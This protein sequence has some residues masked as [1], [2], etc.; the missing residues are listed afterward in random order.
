MSNPD[1]THSFDT[2]L[3]Y[4]AA[5]PQRHSLQGKS[6]SS[7]LFISETEDQRP[8]YNSRKIFVGGL[9][10]DLTEE[11]TTF[12]DYFAKYGEIE[13][14]V[15][16]H[17]RETGKP[18]GFGFVT[19]KDDKSVDLVLQDKFKHKIKNKWVECKRATPKILGTETGAFESNNLKQNS[20][21]QTDVNML[22][23]NYKPYPRKHSMGSMRHPGSK[24]KDIF[25]PP[26]MNNENPFAV[27][28]NSTENER[29]DKSSSVHS[30]NE[31]KSENNCFGRDK[32]K[33]EKTL[34]KANNQMKWDNDNI[35]TYAE[36]FEDGHESDNG[37]DW[38]ISTNDPL[39]CKTQGF[40]SLLPS[41]D[42]GTMFT[43][44][45]FLFNK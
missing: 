27:N 13:D 26:Q 4:Q 6:N 17:D 32:M 1:S 12:V 37:S 36:I 30:D 45:K 2:H 16:I 31:I 29:E 3:S 34:I 18:R 19:Y 9:P 25:L 15:V 10:H 38:K 23:N 44:E 21:F 41:S 5:I 11:E 20:N 40:P 22:P 33:G 24:D 42:F 39:D 43:N 14:H 35:N 28:Q 7:S 8:S